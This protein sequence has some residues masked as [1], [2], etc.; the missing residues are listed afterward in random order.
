MDYERA[1][2]LCHVRS[3]IYRKSKGIK[4][5][6]N[7]RIDLDARVPPEDKMA[8]DWEEHDPRDYDGGSLFMMN[9]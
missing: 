2:E 5:W 8:E 9:D 1:K 7:H 3:A 4:Y 6:K